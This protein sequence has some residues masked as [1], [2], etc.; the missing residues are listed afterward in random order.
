ML[1]LL[2]VES[3]TSLLQ[4][5]YNVDMGISEHRLLSRVGS[6]LVVVC[7]LAAPL[8]ATRC[9]LSSCAKPGTQE[10]STTGCHHQSK[11][12]RGSS[13]L[14]VAISPPCLPTDSLLTTLPAQQ[15]R[16][17]SVSLDHVTPFLAMAKDSSFS[18]GLA[19][20]SAHAP[21]RNSSPGNPAPSFSKS[22]LRL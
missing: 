14:A 17:L 12:F 2:E 3:T 7:L 6:L 16:L 13:V 5:E 22:P 10:Q 4:Y 15:F 19:L 20:T 11:H 9:T 8:C 1:A 18:G 21:N